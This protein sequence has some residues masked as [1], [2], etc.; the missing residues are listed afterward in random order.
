MRSRIPLI[1]KKI[2]D[3]IPRKEI[4]NYDIFQPAAIEEKGGGSRFQ[5]RLLKSVTIFFSFIVQ[6]IY[7]FIFAMLMNY[8]ILHSQSVSSLRSIYLS[9]P[10]SL[11]L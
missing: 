9:L 7:V 3:E 6:S 11:L 8:Q 4:G 10:P 2:S 5:E 1:E